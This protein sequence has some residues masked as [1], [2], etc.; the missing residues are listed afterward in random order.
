MFRSRSRFHSQRIAILL[1][2][3]LLILG[4]CITAPKK[5]ALTAA[6][7]GRFSFPAEKNYWKGKEA[8]L[9]G[10][11]EFP[12][13][14]S[15][16]VPA[17][18]I[19]H[20]SA[21]MGYRG[22]SWGEFLREH[23]IATFRIDYFTPR[24]L[25]QAGRDG[26]ASPYD[27][28]AGLKILA[29]HPRIDAER[30]G[31]MDFSRGGSITL[32]SLNYDPQETGG[33][34]PQA[35]VALYPGCQRVQFGRNLPDV[36]ILILVGGEDVLSFA[37]VCEQRAQEAKAH[38]KDVK[39]VVYPGVHHGFDDNNSRT[40]QWGGRSVRMEANREATQQAR[41]EVL[42]TLRRAFALAPAG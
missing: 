41:G 20:G 38:G 25:N 34:H 4:G 26:P 42:V 11:L 1:G 22:A 18:I 9:V 3:G 8:D 15:G 30:I 33:V 28:Y 6:D 36:P 29:T 24:G 17:M 14:T 2:A 19:M 21:G 35:F 12:E 27:V 10:T 31:V 5:T 37:E 23:G 13:G 16:K 32:L 7:A 40:V 39:T